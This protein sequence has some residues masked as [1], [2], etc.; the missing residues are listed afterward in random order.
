MASLV[1]RGLVHLGMDVSRDAIA[2]AV[3]HP[4]RDV[5]ETDKIFNDE[6]SVRRLIGG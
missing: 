2:V 6:V 3:L 4:D 1:H 5:A